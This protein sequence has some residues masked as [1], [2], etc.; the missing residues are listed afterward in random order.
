MRHFSKHQ[1]L[2]L[3]LQSGRSIKLWDISSG[4]ELTTL[5]KQDPTVADA[6]LDRLLSAAHRLE[7]KGESLRKRQKQNEKELDAA[8]PKQ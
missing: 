8:R 5:T 3:Y 7:L 4:Q 6:L 1:E 2:D